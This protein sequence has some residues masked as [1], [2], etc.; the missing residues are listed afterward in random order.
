LR[1]EQEISD[2]QKKGVGL[3]SHPM[4]QPIAIYWFRQDLRLSDNPALHQAAKAGPVLPIY[5]LDDKTPG[6]HAMG[7]ASRLYLYHS[8][9]ALSESLNGHLALFTGDPL[10]ILKKLIKE[11]SVKGVFWNRLYEPYAIMRDTAIK[12]AL[13]DLGIEV[14][15]HN[16]SLLWE[17]WLI[18][19]SDETPY[20]VFTPFYK[21]GCL[22]AKPPRAPL[23][24]P[25]PL[26]L[27]K[28][29]SG[30]L[31]LDAL[32]L[33]P[34]KKWKE[35]IEALWTI[36]EKGAQKRLNDFL[37]EGLP[38]YRKGRDFPAKPY[39][40][41]LSP[42][43]H[44]GEISPHQIYAAVHKLKG[45]ENT[46]HFLSEI[47]WREFSYNLLYHNPDLPEKNFQKKFDKFPWKKSPAAL[48]AWQKGETGIPFVDAGMRELWQTGYMHNRVRMVVGSFLIKNLLIDWRE[49]EKWFWDCLLDADLANNSA[50]WQWVAGCGADAAP[51]FRIFNPV[52]Q[53]VKFDPEGEY[54]LKYVPELSKMPLKY[55]FNPWEA[56]SDVLDKAGVVLGKTYPKPIV[57]LKASREEALKAF[58]KVKGGIC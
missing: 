15:S 3:Y 16:A 46:A 34:L 39:V 25:N 35:P 42:H 40:S 11:H 38:H 19:K 37:K 1:F 48:K 32:K 33:R 28:K 36:G 21:K 47:G 22:S 52:T 57:D 55:L 45:T 23:P 50:S 27:V 4:S 18:H 9:K 29:P 30:S 10:T 54:T 5:I 43:L 8:L 31:T 13:K 41:R 53:G 12:K 49:G 26:N 6:K 58:E 17:P 51:Y 56:P 14:E 7:G 20:K 2:F 24:T 44:F